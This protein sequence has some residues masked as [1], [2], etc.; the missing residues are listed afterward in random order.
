MDIGIFS[1]SACAAGLTDH[2]LLSAIAP[3]EYRRIR[4]M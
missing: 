3:D 4:G 2:R 1:R